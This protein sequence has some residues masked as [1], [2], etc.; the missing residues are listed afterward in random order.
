MTHAPQTD[1]ALV[2]EHFEG[3]P[4]DRSGRTVFDLARSSGATPEWFAADATPY[5]RLLFS[6]G[7]RIVTNVRT[8]ETHLARPCWCPVEGDH[9]THCG[10]KND[11]EEEA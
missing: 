6:D 1:A 3:K 11:E 5:C 2:L 9:L 4:R 8:K 10:V 7:S